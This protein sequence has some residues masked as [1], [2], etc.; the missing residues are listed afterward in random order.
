MQAVGSV[1]NH[2]QILVCF[3]LHPI[4]AWNT[5][6]F[7]VNITAEILKKEQH[8]QMKKQARIYLIKCIMNED[9]T[10]TQKLYRNAC[11]SLC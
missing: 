3:I 8:P 5:V 2:E 7:A 9:F 6:V 1:F 11:T 10:R 4:F